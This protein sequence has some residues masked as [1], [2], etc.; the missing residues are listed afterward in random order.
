M[1]YI[2]ICVDGVINCMRDLSKNRSLNYLSTHN[3]V[4]LKMILKWGFFDDVR[5]DPKF[6]KAYEEIF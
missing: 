6:V 4:P 1:S 3:P 2:Y 5:E